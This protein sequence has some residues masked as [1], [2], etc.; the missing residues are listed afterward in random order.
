M[1]LHAPRNMHLVTQAAHV[2][3]P[4]TTM[5]FIPGV[6]SVLPSS[7]LPQPARAPLRPKTPRTPAPLRFAQMSASAETTRQQTFE[8]AWQELSDRMRATN[9]VPPLEDWHNVMDVCIRTNEDPAKGIWLLNLMRDLKLKAT[10]G[11][12]ERVLTL[13]NDKNDRAAAFHLVE[14]MFKDKILLG[15]VLLPDGME[16]M[17]RTI[18]PPEAFE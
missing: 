4:L 12:Y 18:L 7:N 9:E 13:C 10:A 8:T 6:P 14:L 11:S 5:A 15:D 3:L 16:E 2:T 17:L 1:P